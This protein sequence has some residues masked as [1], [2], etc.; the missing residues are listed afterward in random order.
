MKTATL[1]ILA[2][3]ALTASAVCATPTVTTYTPSTP[4]LND[5]PYGSYTV[6]GMS[7]TFATG[8]IA[9]ATLNFK[10]IYNWDDSPN[11]LYI[12]LLDNPALG[13]KTFSDTDNGLDPMSGQGILLTMYQ[14]L[15]DTPQDLSYSFTPSELSTLQTYAA[16][17]NEFGLGFGP[18]C[19]FFNDGVS[20]V[21]TTTSP[22]PEP[23][24][25]G[26]LAV[27]GVIAF[28][29]RRNKLARRIYA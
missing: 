3:V 12:H 9:S 7:T 19:H 16:S 14:N 4:D 22:A 13:I 24:T 23:A 21:I 18:E 2:V 10:N 5:L 8:S 28:F 29:K 6:W 1:V 20:L 27:G 25:C 17:G 11:K 15:P 26:L